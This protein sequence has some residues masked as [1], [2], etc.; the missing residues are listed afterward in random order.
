MDSN[1]YFLT[2]VLL[3]LWCCSVSSR[4]VL[5]SRK[6]LPQ[7]KLNNPV[8][9]GRIQEP[10][11]AEASGLVASRKHPGVYYSIQD[12]LN[13]DNVY[14]FKENGE[15]IGMLLRNLSLIY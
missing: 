15:S 12:S 2:L 4:V 13:P 14:V 3:G 10:E 5:K 1:K 11:L 7:C 6:S 9:T 8:E